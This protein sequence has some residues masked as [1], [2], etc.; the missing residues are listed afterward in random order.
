MYRGKRVKPATI[1][2]KTLWLM[3]SLALLLTV[4][5]GGTIAFLIQETGEL[6]NEFQLEE[7]ATKVVIENDEVSI[8]NTSDTR[9]AYI[10]AKVIANW[11]KEEN[12]VPVAIYGSAPKAGEDY[13][14][15]LF[16]PESA[17]EE[18]EGTFYYCQPVQANASTAV[19]LSGLTVHT[20]APEEGYTLAVEVLAQAIQA[21]GT[22][23]KDNKPIAR[24]W[25]VDIANGTV[26]AAN[27]E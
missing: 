2:K 3:V 1:H 23:S 19:L 20:E 5:V 25:G 14:F 21:D 18:Y 16:G 15:T 13:S 22:D 10:R 26:S 8:Q 27:N 6:E 11:V 9:A 4:T 7:I 12:G 24:A 17:W